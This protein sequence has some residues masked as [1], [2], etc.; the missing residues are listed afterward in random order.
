MNPHNLGS[1]VK[2][3]GKYAK[4]QKIWFTSR[5]DPQMTMQSNLLKAELKY[6]TRPR[7]YILTPGNL[8]FRIPGMKHGNGNETSRLVYKWSLLYEIKLTHFKDKK[9][10]EHE[11]CI[12]WKKKIEKC[13]ELVI[14]SLF[15]EPFPLVCKNAYILAHFYFVR[16]SF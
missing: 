1:E 8:G 7:A 6:V 5:M 14:S 12:N 13:A 16:L 4:S 15:L 2:D 3:N 10:Q 11:L 9:S